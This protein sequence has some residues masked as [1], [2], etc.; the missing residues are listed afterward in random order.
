MWAVD[1]DTALNWAFRA[2]TDA[3]F[4]GVHLDVEPWTLPDWPD[5]ARGLM[6]SY[7]TLVEEMTEVASVA[8]DLAWW[9]ADVHR[10]VVSR[11]AR[12]CDSVTVLA[13]R[14]D[15]AGILTAAGAMLR[16]CETAATRYRIGVETQPPST[17]IPTATTFGD[18]GETAM[19]TQLAA[20]AARIQRPL[21]DGF[22]VHHLASWRAMP[23]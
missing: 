4:D 13:Y 10:D 2:T 14:D 1:H 22:A 12:Q 5:N 17:A 16:L 7:A 19:D 15:A 8:V 11:V 23:L 9:L 20:V 6:G 21:F 3:V 18:D